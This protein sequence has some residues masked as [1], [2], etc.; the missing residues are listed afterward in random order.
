LPSL[1]TSVSNTRSSK[2]EIILIDNGSTDDSIDVFGNLLPPS[3]L[4]STKII[5]H[6]KNT[7]VSAAFAQGI[8]RSS[9]PWTVILNNDITFKPDW[10]PLISQAISKNNDPKVVTFLGTI[11]NHDGS[12]IESQG[13][14]FFYRGKCLNINN[15]KLYSSNDPSLQSSPT[16]IWGAPAACVVYHRDTILKVGNFDPDF[17]AYEEDVDL[18]LRL[19][20]L[21]YKTLYIPQA[22]SYHLGGATSSKMGNFRHCMDAKNWFFIIIKNYSLKELRANL[23]PIIEERLRNLSYLVKKTPLRLVFNSIVA[24]Y[25]GVAKQIPAMIRKRKAIKKLIKSAT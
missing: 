5:L 12:K 14:K 10:F 25:W 9:F 4:L 6:T 13:L 22:I 24:T 3:D 11:L 21:G 2:F 23:F 16:L 20:N 15:G 8:E 1:L 19:S 18:A 7:G 17:F